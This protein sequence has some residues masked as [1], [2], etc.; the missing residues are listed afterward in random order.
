M[1]SSFLLCSGHERLRRCA[2]RHHPTASA[3][4]ILPALR[5]HLPPP[6]VT[7]HIHINNIFLWMQ[8][9]KRIC[10][11]SL[12][13]YYPINNSSRVGFCCLLFK[14]RTISANFEKNAV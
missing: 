4:S 12:V 14:K 8:F 2:T 9:N 7:A 11:N 6:W 1:S 5:L 13:S 3:A 10:S